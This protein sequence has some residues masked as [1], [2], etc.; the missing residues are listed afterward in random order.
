MVQF[1]RFVE[2]GRLAL[3]TYGPEAGKMVT[4]VDVIDHKRVVID[5]PTTGVKRQQIPVRWIS[6][7]DMKSEVQRGA[8]T[9]IV[10]KIVSTDGV[11]AKWAQ[12]SWAK[13]V[14]SRAARKNLGDFDRFKAMALKKRKAHRVRTEINKLKRK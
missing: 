6:L 4:I 11:L 8:R 7:T 3:V 10:K 2:P 1:K 14:A 13:K 12:T 9:G 5:G